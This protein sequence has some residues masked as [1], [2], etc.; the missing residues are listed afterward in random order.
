MA[1]EWMQ[2]RAQVPPEVAAAILRLLRERHGFRD[3]DW[4]V[5]ERREDYSRVDYDPI[6]LRTR[7]DY[8]YTVDWRDL[9][10]EE[11]S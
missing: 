3:T 7:A 4:C 1:D 10:A 8:E 9:T 5:M 6:P 2:V 11:T